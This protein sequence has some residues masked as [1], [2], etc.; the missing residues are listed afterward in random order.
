MIFALSKVFWAIA[1]PGNLFILGLLGAAAGALSPWPKLRKL[2]RGGLGVL[3]AALLAIA[4]LPV[5]DWLI[6]P[7]ERRFPPP[8]ELPGQVDG[9]IVL[10]GMI[11]LEI[12]AAHGRPELDQ[13]ADRLVAFVA[14][15]RKYPEAKLV[16]TG[17]SGLLADSEHREADFAQDALQDLGVELARVL[18]ERNSR[19]THEN[20]LFTYVR[21]APGPE[22]LWLLIT[23]ASHMPRAVG[24]FRRIGWQVTPYPVDYYTDGGSLR[25]DFQRGLEVLSTALREW[26][27]LTA[28]RLLG[29]TDRLFPA[30]RDDRV[31]L[32]RV[33]FGK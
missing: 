32:A 19:N 25:F 22:E 15:A 10:G 31:S 17:G 11:N 33:H 9:V 7:L 8:R 18:F 24:V 21:V 2:A 16:F 13:A 23:S 20:A 30:P 14:L 4:V 29:W 27:G 28:Y 26:I 5:G 6:S 3:L 12:S 1:N